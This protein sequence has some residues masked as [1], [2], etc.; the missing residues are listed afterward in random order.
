MCGIAGVVPA[1]ELDPD[2]VA[3][4]LDVMRFRG[5]DDHGV[6][7]A[8][9]ATVEVGRDVPT[10]PLPANG[11]V[12]V[13][14]RL[15]ILDLTEA[16]WQPMSSPDRR[17]WIVFNG[18]IYNYVELREELGKAGHKFH[19][20]SD[21]EVLLAAWSEWGPQALSKFVGMF[22][23]AL[24][25]V[26]ERKLF[27]ARDFFGIKPLYYTEAGGGVAFASTPNAL[28]TVPGVTR[29]VNPARLH[30]YLVTGITDCGDE[31]MFADIRQ[32]PAAHYM[33][34]DLDAPKAE[35][36]VEYWRLDLAQE[37]SL[38]KQAAATRLRELFLENVRL[39]L[40]SDVPVGTALS[41]GI[42]SSAIV[43]GMRRLDPS[44]RIHT[45]SQ[46]TDDPVVGEEKWVDIVTHAADSTMHKVT[47]TADELVADLD[48]LVRA[49]GEPFGSTSIYAQYR[50][51]ALAGA[52]G[53][54]VMLDGQGADEVLAGYQYYLAA[55]MASLV[56]SG[57][58]LAAYRFYREASKRPRV[59]AA[60]LRVAMFDFLVPPRLQ[61]A[62]RRLIGRGMLPSWLNEDW[63]VSRGAI[64]GTPGTFGYTADRRVLRRALAKTLVE[65]SLP[66]L[67]RYEDRN[68]MAFSIESRVPFLT[69]ELVQFVFTLPE[70]HI[71]GPDGTTKAVFRD[72]CRGLVPDPILDR[73][74]KI[75][76]ETPER[77]WLQT[78]RPW[79]EGLLRS[80]DAKRIP[81]LRMEEVEK[82]WR[83]VIEGRKP[84]SSQVWRWINLIAWSR[85]FRVTYD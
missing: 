4:F 16:G 81:A 26:E 83:E 78:L 39:H 50:V 59:D 75:G 35:R 46:I 85:E 32:L 36:P 24:L 64:E 66:M 45:F 57:R 13:H 43:M 52:A 10:R 37:T 63:F 58:V 49:Q 19:T 34:V 82:E 17:F 2:L 5:P 69:P 14:R 38:S 71:V 11:A 29:R 53:I 44:A 54:K 79:V 30:L 28:L 80:A 8:R 23:F 72:A 40:R 20:G 62:L 42:D 60:W 3:R 9:G 51:F 74:D 21:T 61:P 65:T 25:D 31:T 15:S 77:Q 70:E 7:V 12:L 55:R 33:V 68:S 84:F 6:L 1:S 56:R 18:E 41:G 22:A 48:A 47:P 73:K 76:F 67:L 27:L